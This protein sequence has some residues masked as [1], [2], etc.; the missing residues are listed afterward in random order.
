MAQTQA[1]EL[2]VTLLETDPVIWRRIVVPGEMTLDRIHRVLQVAMGWE[3]RHLYEFEVGDRR[4]GP[5]DED[6]DDD[7]VDDSDI[8]LS[9]VVSVGDHLGYEYD[10]GDSWRLEVVVESATDGPSS[11]KCAACTDGERAGPPEDCG[12]VDGYAE[13]LEV[14]A[15]P[16]QEDHE[17]LRSWLG[18][19]FN[20]G[21]FS[22]VAVNAGLQGIR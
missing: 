10:F 8:R 9:E 16:S 11:L 19:D 20:P 7:L 14:L 12:G 5:A 3:N 4:F 6:A 1:F 17:E 2:K 13:L 15:D 21:L 18:D 22:L